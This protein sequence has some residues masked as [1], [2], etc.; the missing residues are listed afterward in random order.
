MLSQCDGV[1]ISPVIC[2]RHFRGIAGV[3]SSLSFTPRGKSSISFPRSIQAKSSPSFACYPQAKLSSSFACSP[4]PKLSQSFVCSSQA[5]LSSSL[6]CSSQVKLSSSLA[7]S[8]AKSSFSLA[9]SQRVLPGRLD[10]SALP[11]KPRWPPPSQLLED[12][13]TR[14]RGDDPDCRGMLSPAAPPWNPRVGKTGME[15]FLAR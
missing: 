5:K 13:S 14:G 3:K 15:N 2:Q 12:A 7:C 6:A 9:S 8:Q 1:K 4:Q 11:W 10:S